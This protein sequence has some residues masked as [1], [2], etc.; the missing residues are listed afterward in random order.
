[1]TLRGTVWGQ[2]RH[3][4]RA[5]ITSGLPLLAD[6]FRAGQHVSKVPNAEVFSLAWRTACRGYNER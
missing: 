6:N 1:M 4:D 3:F 2:T 5:P